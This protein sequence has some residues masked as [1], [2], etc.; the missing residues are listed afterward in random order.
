M[1]DW[2][3]TYGTLQFPEVLQ[4]VSGL[5][6]SGREAKAYGYSQYQMVDKLYPG[7]IADSE[8]ITAGQVY[9]GVDH[10]AWGLLDRFED[11]I[12]QRQEV[13]VHLSGGPSVI[14]HAYVVPVRYAHLLSGEP[15]I[16]SWFAAHY[17][18]DYVSRCR[19]FY[20]MITLT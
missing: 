4:A 14:A 5:I 19:W 6:S 3:F 13:E 12:Y 20:H 9:A 16:S 8:G 11:P 2:L 10:V 17:L 18:E 7:M 1:A 15:W